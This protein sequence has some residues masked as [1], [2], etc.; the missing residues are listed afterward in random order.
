MRLD[1]THSDVLKH[2]F[3]HGV[4]FSTQY[5]TILEEIKRP[6]NSTKFHQ[7]LRNSRD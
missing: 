5:R 2:A 4:L 7:L 6:D 3:D 1:L